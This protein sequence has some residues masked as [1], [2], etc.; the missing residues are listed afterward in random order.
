M[1]PTGDLPHEALRT[2]ARRVVDAGLTARRYRH[3]R[4]AVS[5]NSARGFSQNAAALGDM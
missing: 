5:F 1:I 4:A 2:F 3:H